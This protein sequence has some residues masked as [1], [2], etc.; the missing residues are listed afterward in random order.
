M[1]QATSSGE[2]SR[3]H[4][5]A[6]HPFLF[7]A[8]PCL[9][10]YS[11]NVQYAPIGDLGVVLAKSLVG[12]ATVY[13]PLRLVFKSRDLA[14]VI[15][16]ALIVTAF[17]FSP[18]RA[19]LD[20]RT[21]LGVD[22]GHVRYVFAINASALLVLGLSLFHQREALSRWTAKANGFGGILVA[23]AL[24]FSVLGNISPPP[25]ERSQGGET[26]SPI[27]FTDTSIFPENSARPDIYYIVLDGYGRADVLADLYDQDNSEFI[28]YLAREGFYVAESSTSNYPTTIHSLSSALNMDYIPALFPDGAESITPFSLGDLIKDSRLVRILK[29]HFGYTFVAHSSGWYFSSC[30]AADLYL[31][32][33]NPIPGPSELESAVFALTPVRFAIER[34]FRRWSPYGYHRREILYTLEGLPEVAQIEAAT[35]TF[36][37][38]LVPHPPF[39]FGPEG[40]DVSSRDEPYSLQDH[41]QIERAGSANEALQE[42][43]RKYRDQVVFVNKMV[44]KAIDG[45]LRN[46]ATPPII[47]LQGDHGPGSLRSNSM[48]EEQDDE[49][50][51]AW[52]RFSILN[53]YYFP[54]GGSSQLYPTIMPVNTF[55]VM[56][57]YYFG[58]ELDL[59]APRKIWSGYDPVN[60]FKEASYPSGSPM[61]NEPRESSRLGGAP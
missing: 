34:L 31:S 1:N 28:E 7:A 18:L 10:I 36:A 49:K 26:M 43:R 27:R 5:W 14:A 50:I 59:V 8:F 52:E 41:A 23:I 32:P 3:K 61:S 21:F 56:L 6:V 29:E 51:K 35:F 38:V 25:R 55:R 53:A 24:V 40:E 45:I 47:I 48:L 13:L 46:S 22:L 17:S 15:A 4:L 30:E 57:R 11:Q 37:H 60:R 19:V 20:G 12:A 54:F 39:V 33:A 9:S 42:Y 16:S 44:R 2:S 58:A